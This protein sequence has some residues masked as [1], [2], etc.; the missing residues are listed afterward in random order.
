MI[1]LD[2]RLLQKPHLWCLILVLLLTACTASTE[3]QTLDGHLTELQVEILKL[4]K[5]N[6]DKASIERL[7]ER[8]SGQLDLLIKARAGA[9]LDLRA[10]QAGIEQL[11]AKLED[12]NFRLAQLSQ[13]VTA[14]G[15]ELRALRLS[16]E[17]RFQPPPAPTPQTMDP[18]EPQ[19]LYDNAYADYQRGNYDLAI[20]G[21][22][23]FLEVMADSE[24]A[25][26]AT[27]WIGEC[28]YRQRKFQQA[29]DQFDQVLTRFTASDRMPSALLKKGYAYLELGQRSQGV[30]QLQSV[31]C[32]HQDTDEAH[33]ARQRLSALGID[34][35]C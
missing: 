34:V 16:R 33:L 19:T 12:T 27:Y 30:V 13:E 4:Q 1:A 23:N 17:Q 35:D 14:T 10:L 8:L 31:V 22:L 25:D 18:A 2:L 24:Q 26:N 32:E 3:L 6:A 5:E 7:G 9:A 29:V 20:L 28:F 21:F 11:D 15:Q